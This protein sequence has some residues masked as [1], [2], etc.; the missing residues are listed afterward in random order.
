MA[1][2][3][4]GSAGRQ[5]A[6]WTAQQGQNQ[7]DQVNQIYNNSYNSAYN[8]LQPAYN[9]ARDITNQSY[10]RASGQLNAGY[11]AGINQFQQNL[12]NQT[13]AINQGYGQAL[14]QLQSGYGQAIDT[15]QPYYDQTMQGYG[16]YQN[17][18]GLGGAEGTKAA[19][20]AFQAGPGYQWNVDQATGQAQRAANKVGGLYSGN[21][22]D[23]TTRLA[24]NL[25]NQE[26]GGWVNHLQGFQGAAG[27][28]SQYL[29]G[30][31]E[32]EGA[33][34]AGL[35]TEQAGAL[36]NVYGTTG[37]QIANAQIQK[38][39]GQAA[40]TGDWGQSRANI[41]LGRGQ[42]LAN[43]DLTYGGNQAEAVNQYYQTLIPAG[44]QGFQAGQQ[45]AANRTGAITGALQLGM[46]A[47]GGGA[48]GG[49]AG[50]GG[51]SGIGGFLSKLFGK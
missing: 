15:Y 42:G 28:A 44:Q 34:L 49:A 18:L 41:A 2:S 51:F 8:R 11:D 47:L 17:A 29:S 13:G 25:A 10:N 33:G 12:N 43:L 9:R 36:S 22:Q 1:S 6:V 4:S 32:K 20:N 3:F 37:G 50:G 39:A 24:S 30:L 21:T 5:G 23:A 27:N 35:S 45:A 26:Y 48:G 31:Y 46:S 16:M 40:L 38:G 19:Q 14:Q 7:L